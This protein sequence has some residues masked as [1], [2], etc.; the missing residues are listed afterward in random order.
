VGRPRRVASRVRFP[1]AIRSPRI[2]CER[3]IAAHLGL[4]Q[5]REGNEDEQDFAM[6][7]AQRQR[8]PRH[9]CGD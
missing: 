4:R 5:H 1:T 9:C 7:K 2:Y 3:I 8:S 6:A